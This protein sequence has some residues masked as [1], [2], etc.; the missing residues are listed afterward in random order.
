MS[1]FS[2]W[3]G[4]LTYYGRLLSAYDLLTSGLFPNNY[5]TGHVNALVTQ[6]ATL[7]TALK[8]CFD[9]KTGLPATYINFTTQT[10]IRSTYQAGNITYNATNAAQAGTLLLEWYRLSDLT[11]DE[12]FRVLV[13]LWYH[14]ST[15]TSVLISL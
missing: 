3:N 4:P 1:L 15:F 10:P 2:G 8:P 5:S 13:S 14:I 6:A 7:A 9:T 12:S 11:G